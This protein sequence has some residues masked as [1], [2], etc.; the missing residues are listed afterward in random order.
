[1]KDVS[2]AK[3]QLS[4]DSDDEFGSIASGSALGSSESG[5]GSNFK[6]SKSSKLSV[7][8]EEKGR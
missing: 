2:K 4:D 6:S 5:S 1:M 7:V 8:E 3:Q